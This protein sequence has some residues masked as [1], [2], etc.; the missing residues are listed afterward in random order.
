MII[1]QEFTV[2]APR[3]TVAAFFTD[4]QRVGACIPGLEGVEEVGPNHYS[5]R[6]GIR[7]GP[8]RAAFGGSLRLDASEAPA[9]LIA[10]GEGRDRATGSVATVRFTA[11][12]TESS[13]G[14]THVKA[15]A[16]VA[17][18]GRMSQYGTG[19][20]RAAAGEIVREFANRAN[21]ALAAEA[22]RPASASSEQAVAVAAP[23][24]TATAPPQRG[25][26]ALLVRALLRALREKFTRRRRGGAQ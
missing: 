21:A 6:L 4:V 26:L 7:M 13:P 5:A 25:L 8:I 20:V 23:P 24:T 9:R 16:D 11:D 3:E 22:A 17:L 15:V 12:L 18:R 19:V 2:N 1:E 14:T 10:H